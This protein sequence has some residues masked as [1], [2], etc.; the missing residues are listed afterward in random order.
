MSGEKQKFTLEDVHQTYKK[1]DAWWTV[2]LVDPVAA[3]LILPTANHTNITPNQLSIFSFIIGMTA[4]Y[5][6]YL[7]DYTALIIGALLYHLSFIID[8]M[9]G[10]IARLKGTGSTFG[11][12]LDISLDH[13]RVV[14]C[15]AALIYSQFRMTEEI[16]YLY[17]GFVF[18]FAY[19][20]RHINA[21]QLYKL[22]REMRGKIRKARRKLKK[23]ARYA[24][25]V[26]EPPSQETK[27]E[28]GDDDHSNDEGEEESLDGTKK[29]A[30]PVAKAPVKDAEDPLGKKKVDLQ[31]EFK[32][33]FSTYMK[34]REFFLN[35]RI[36]MHLF[37]GIEFQM[38]I[39]VL[40]PILG[41]V[42]ESIFFGAI[43]LLAFE[44]TILYKIWLS[45]KDFEREFNRIKKAT[46]TIEATLSEEE[47][48]AMV[49]G[50]PSSVAK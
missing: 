13:I 10:K 33:K 41:L 15:G 21:L 7:G 36:R 23:T 48:E 24:G 18:L 6:F 17:L 26:I 34:L 8:C 50:A 29:Q 30:Q 42:K 37:S 40:A 31:Q 46:E 43:L 11:M 2:L 28:E 32:S 47:K 4:A 38:F 1:K 9:D 20:T 22:R 35:R 14:I 16:A 5:C 19:G 3:R 27:R 12:L 39:F 44:G 45:T 49:T 25:I